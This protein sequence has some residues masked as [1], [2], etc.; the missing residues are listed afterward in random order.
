MFLSISFGEILY[1]TNGV[2]ENFGIEIV[3]SCIHY[4]ENLSLLKVKKNARI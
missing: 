1:L 3:N 2:G 4:P